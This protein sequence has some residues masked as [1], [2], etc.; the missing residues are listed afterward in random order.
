[1]NNFT[2]SEMRLII[3]NSAKNNMNL[4]Y[5]KPIKQSQK[6]LS[7]RINLIRT[8]KIYIKK[9]CQFAPNRDNILYLSILYLDIILSKNKISLQYDK[10]LKYLCLCCFLLSLKFI[11][12]YDLSKRIIKNFCNNYK[13]EYKIFEIQCL[14]LLEHNLIYSTVYDYINMILAKESKKLISISSSLLYQLCEDNLFISYSPFYIS[15]A[16]VLLAK[17]SINDKRHNHYDKYFHDQ[18]VKYL[19]KM[20]S[21]VINP[22]QIKFPVKIDSNNDNT[23]NNNSDINN[24][25]NNNAKYNKNKYDNNTTENYKHNRGGG[26]KSS[27]INIFTNNNIQNNIVIINEYSRRKDDEDNNNNYKYDNIST[28][29]DIQI[30]EGRCY[31]TK[32][33]TPLKIFVNRNSNSKVYF[34]DYNQNKLTENDQ[35]IKYIKEYNYNNEDHQNKNYLRKVNTVLK[36]NTLLKS[37]FNPEEMKD[38]YSHNT[39]KI[40]RI[41]KNKNMD[42]SHRIS[43]CSYSSNNLPKFISNKTINRSCHR[44]NKNLDEEGIKD[45]TISKDIYIQNQNQT[46]SSSS[47]KRRIIYMNKSS[48]NFELVSGVP[49]EK[50][51]KLS[52]NLSKT[53]MKTN[54]KS[55]KFLKFK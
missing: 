22:P 21:Y 41:K 29:N 55:S 54:D 48:L 52:R 16:I 32:N 46:K 10:N 31:N 25:I 2:S 28:V 51:E 4:P 5:L 20:F 30:S 19:Y 15:V 26:L 40:P 49:K 39:H 18:R 17:N 44:I 50:L 14:I 43:Y 8:L 27:S 3:S 11:G 53:L 36:N 47:M 7:H 37:Y 6:I 12:N 45:G 13:D 38:N 42:Q 24:N 9:Y 23:K 35:G 1:M 33:K 34:D